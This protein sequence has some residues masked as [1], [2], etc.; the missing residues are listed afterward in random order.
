MQQKVIRYVDSCIDCK[1]FIDKITYEPLFFHKVPSKNWEFVAVDLYGPIPSNNHVVVVQDLGSRFPAAKLVTSPRSTKV[2]PA[3]KEI[4]NAYGNLEIQISDNGPPFKSKAMEN[5]TQNKNIEMKKIPP[6]HPSSNPVETLM[7]PLGKTM[8]IAHLHHQP[9]KKALESFLQ[10]YRDTPHPPT[11]VSPAAM[12]FRDDKQTHFPRKPITEEECIKVR[13][14]DNG[15]KQLRTE[16][17]NCSKYRK[18]DDTREGDK[19]LLRNYTKQRKFDP[20]FIPKPY[21]VLSTNEHMII[22]E[23]CQKETMLKRHRDDVKHLPRTVSSKTNNNE[24]NHINDKCR[25][26]H[27]N[28]DFEDFARQL[29]NKY[30]DCSS[31]FSFQDRDVTYTNGESE[32]VHDMERIASSLENLQIRD[33]NAPLQRSARERKPNARYFNNETIT[34][35]S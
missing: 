3:L 18:E 32:V 13:N 12:M 1:A 31:P 7:W 27:C 26:C 9:E 16:P 30:N 34:N 33:D 23:N 14:R 35:F 29:S 6:L 19:V 22:V 11:G 10:N 25:H 21:K 24:N 5:F 20:V 4:Y 8:K 15:L 28:C 17:I 2:I